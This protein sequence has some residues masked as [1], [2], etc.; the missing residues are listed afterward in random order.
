MQQNSDLLEDTPKEHNMFQHP[1]QVYYADESVCHLI[2]KP[3]ALWARRVSRRYVP[4]NKKKIMKTPLDKSSTLM[5][6]HDAKN[7]SHAW[8]DGE[9]SSTKYGLSDKKVG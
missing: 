2:R 4:I 1:S 3:Q 5:V 7:F 9:I 8:T 6:I